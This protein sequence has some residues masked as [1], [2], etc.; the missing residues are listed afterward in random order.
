MMN[1]KIPFPSE[2]EKNKSI[3]LIVATV[4]PQ[5]H[6][7]KSIEEMFR[8]IGV[9]GLFFGV[10][11][12]VFLAMLCSFFC[13]GGTLFLAMERE[14]LTAI[15]L[16]SMSPFLYGLLQVLTT[17]HQHHHYRYVLQHRYGFHKEG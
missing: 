8:F 13:V 6:F 7:G 12:S 9:R 2:E 10:E 4:R 11:D 15:L 17:W 14:G 16:F 5:K 1:E 3:S